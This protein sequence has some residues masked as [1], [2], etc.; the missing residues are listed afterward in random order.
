MEE[1]CDGLAVDVRTVEWRT[2]VD[3]CSGV[4]GNAGDDHAGQPKMKSSSKSTKS[5]SN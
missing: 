2:N 1:F 5:S 3:D 4:G